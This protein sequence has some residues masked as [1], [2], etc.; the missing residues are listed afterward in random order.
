M[1]KNKDLIYKQ[2]RKI[3]TSQHFVKSKISCDLL[4]YLVEASLEGRNPKEY[5]IGVELF[6]KKYE[7]TDKPDSNIR[8][9]IHNVRKKLKAYYTDEGSKD[10]IVFVVEKGKYRVRF[11]SQKDHRPPKDNRFLLPFIISLSM[12]LVVGFLFIK[13]LNEEHNPWKKLPV[14]QSFADNDKRTLLVL[15]DYFVFSGDLPTGNVGIYRDF[16]IN[17]EVEFEHLIDKN[18]EL[19]QTLSKSHLTYLSKMAVFCQNSIYKVFAQ[20]EGDIHVKLSS[21]LQPDDLKNNNIIFVGNY[22]NLGLFEN[23]IRDLDFPF[24]ISSTSELLISANDPCAQIYEP[25]DSSA[26]ETDYALVINTSGFSDNRFLFFL[27]SHDIGN[28]SAVNQLTSPD[29]LLQLSQKHPKQLQS[30]DFKA[31][32]KVEGIN[33]TDLSFELLRVD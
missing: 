28:I 3:T 21:D 17:S 9:Y 14:W 4:S 27:S 11:D 16:S 5:T 10:P 31:L 15:G 26:K 1:Q 25:E 29:Y 32:Y 6:G 13:Q 7:D 33:K 18:P 24:G 23:I 12:L 8:V 30:N 2:L 19:I 20:T 22:K